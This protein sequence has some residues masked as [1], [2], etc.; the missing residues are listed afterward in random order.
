MNFIDICGRK[1]IRNVYAKQNVVPGTGGNLNSFFK[2]KSF[3]GSCRKMMVRVYQKKSLRDWFLSL[4]V[5]L[6]YGLALSNQMPNSVLS[7]CP[8]DAGIKRG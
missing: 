1:A 3:S 4:P 6:L 2:K 5:Q 8:V 7:I